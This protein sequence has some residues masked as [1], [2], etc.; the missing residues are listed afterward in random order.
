[1]AYQ[2]EI[3]TLFIVIKR[4]YGIGMVAIWKE[5]KEYVWWY[6]K[7]MYIYKILPST[8]RG[9]PRAAGNFFFFFV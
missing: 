2:L 7:Y 3:V 4:M 5:K 6:M 8:N 1:M 9:E